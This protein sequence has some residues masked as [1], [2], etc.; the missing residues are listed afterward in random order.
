MI[1]AFWQAPSTNDLLD[2]SRRES[3]LPPVEFRPINLG[4]L[5]SLAVKPFASRAEQAGIEFYLEI[6]PKP[7]IVLGQEIRLQR[8]IANLVGNAIKFTAAGGWVT[9]G[10]TSEGTEANLWIEDTGIGIPPADLPHIFRRSHK[11]SN[12]AGYSGSGLGLSMVMVIIKEHHGQVF[13]ESCPGRTRFD[14]RLPLQL[15]KTWER[16]RVKSLTD[17]KQREIKDRLI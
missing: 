2:L 11:G 1:S 9:V 14:V 4:E 6:P 10:L 12:T 3:G 13:V 5:L 17:G 16:E 7:A 15:Q 8:A